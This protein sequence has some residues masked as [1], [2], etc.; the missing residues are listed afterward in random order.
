MN[1]VVEFE[2]HNWFDELKRFSIGRGMNVNFI[3]SLDPEDWKCVYEGGYTPEEA[4][5]EIFTPAKYAK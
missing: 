3:E 1:K 2:F 5:A 4:F